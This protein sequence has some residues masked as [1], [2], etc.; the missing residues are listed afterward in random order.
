MENKCLRLLAVSQFVYLHIKRP[1][2]F[3]PRPV[4]RFHTQH[5]IKAETQLSIIL[6]LRLL[7]FLWLQMTI[8]PFI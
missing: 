6:Q 2:E 1:S 8:C 3:V 7:W 5:K 4:N